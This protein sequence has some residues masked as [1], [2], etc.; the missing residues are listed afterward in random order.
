[1]YVLLAIIV[2]SDVV[3]TDSVTRTTTAARL[4]AL[5]QDANGNA[6]MVTVILPEQQFTRLLFC[7]II[8]IVTSVV[9]IIITINRHG[10]TYMPETFIA[11]C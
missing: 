7:K 11:L 4:F 9:V 2:S 10:I 5:A 3:R 1:M 8:T 6:K